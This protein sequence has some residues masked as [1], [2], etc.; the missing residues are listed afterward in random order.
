MWVWSK[1]FPERINQEG[2]RWRYTININNAMEWA[3]SQVEE[4]EK[5]SPKL[6]WPSLICQPGNEDQIWPHGP[7]TTMLYPNTGLSH[8][9]PWAEWIIP[10]LSCSF[11]IFSSSYKKLLIQ[12]L[13][14]LFQCAFQWCFPWNTLIAFQFVHMSF[15]FT[16]VASCGFSISATW[17]TVPVSWARR[18]GISRSW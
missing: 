18:N 15:R 10:P 16:W 5:S 3:G 2:N 6:T 8:L 7:V 12:E 1:A 9:K 14:V 11:P 13:V 17:N 4:K